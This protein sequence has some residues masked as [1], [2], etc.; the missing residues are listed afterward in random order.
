VNQ[1]R[2]GKKKAKLVSSGAARGAKNVR[3]AS[4]Q[5]ESEGAIGSG[6]RTLYQDVVKEPLPDDMLA[7]LEKLGS[8]D[9][10]DA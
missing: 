5:L 1:N 3:K 9:D 4:D 10:N 7:L 2:D 6:L 8:M